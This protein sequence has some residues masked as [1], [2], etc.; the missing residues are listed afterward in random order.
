MPSIKYDR[1]IELD[2]DY[3]LAYSWKARTLIE[4]VS[5]GLSGAEAEVAFAQADAAIQ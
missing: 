3:G 5:E 2:P 4:S 1:A